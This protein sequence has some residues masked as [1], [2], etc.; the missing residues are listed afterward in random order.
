MDEITKSLATTFAVSVGEKGSFSTD[1]QHP[2]FH[3]FKTKSDANSQ[4][5]RRKNYLERQKL[6]RCDAQKLAR[7]IVEDTLSD[8]D[9]EFFENEDS[10]LEDE[11]E[12]L[13]GKENTEGRKESRHLC[14]YSSKP[15]KQHK[16]PRLMLSEWLVDI[17]EDFETTCYVMPCPIGKRNLV[18]S[19]QGYTTASTKYGVPVQYEFASMLPN[20]NR[21]NCSRYHKYAYTILDC[22]YS[23]VENKY[24]CLDLLCWNGHPF[25]DCETEFR[26]YWLQ[27]KFSEHPE[28]TKRSRFNKSPFEILPFF[29]CTPQGILTALHHFPPEKLDGLWFFHKETHYHLGV[30]PLVGW[31][32]PHMVPSVLKIDIPE[33]YMKIAEKKKKQPRTN[34][35]HDSQMDASGDQNL[36]DKETR[37]AMPSKTSNESWTHAN[38][39]SLN[40]DTIQKSTVGFDQLMAEA[41]LPEEDINSNRT[42]F[43][44]NW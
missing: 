41:V 12:K 27:T 26:F 25:L 18:T 42:D 9:D 22:V 35:E 17:P 20:G 5:A 15:R 30:T 11:N 13:N 19:T 14:S 10:L 24:Y 28:I 6:K 39:N 29:P 4:N 43:T 8:F 1:K 7:K 40:E 38:P 32:K 3:Q 16:T 21:P 23:P 37:W 33:E 36:E 2:R 34:V 31:L 44:S